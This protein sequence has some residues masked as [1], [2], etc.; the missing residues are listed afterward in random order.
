MQMREG[1]EKIIPESSKSAYSKI[2][3]SKN[4][5]RRLLHAEVKLLSRLYN[6][7]R[8]RVGCVGPHIQFSHAKRILWIMNNPTPLLKHVSPRVSAAADYGHTIVTVC[9]FAVATVNRCF[10]VCLW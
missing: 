7:E 1:A 4:T 8:V 5:L 2:T 3:L 6:V 10:Y 9:S